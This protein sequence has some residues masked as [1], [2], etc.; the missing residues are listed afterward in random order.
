M[1]YPDFMFCKIFSFQDF[2][3]L[4][5]VNIPV[6]THVLC[7]YCLYDRQNKAGHNSTIQKMDNKTTTTETWK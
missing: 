2:K 6:I 3:A 1:L 4:Q 7:Q 5:I